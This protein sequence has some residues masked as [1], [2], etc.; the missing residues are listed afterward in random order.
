MRWWK[1][2]WFEARVAAVWAFLIW[3]RIGLARGMDDGA[4]NNFTVNGS[5]SVSDADV[6][7]GKLMR[8]CLAEND[9]RFAGYDARLLRPTTVPS[10]A[11]LATHF[12]RG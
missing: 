12:L 10:L 1:R 7:P 3:E 2:P 9:R 11:R 8:I 6:S 5:Q 4:D